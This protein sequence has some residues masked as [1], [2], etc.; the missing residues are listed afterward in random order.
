VEVDDGYY[1]AV[2]P[3]TLGQIS[4]Y[5]SYLYDET[6]FVPNPNP[7][8]NPNSN[9]NQIQWILGDGYQI[10]A[11]YYRYFQDGMY[12]VGLGPASISGAAPGVPTEPATWVIWDSDRVQYSFVINTY[13][14]FFPAN[15]L[16]TYIRLKGCTN[17]TS[18]ITNMKSPSCYTDNFTDYGCYTYTQS[19]TPHTNHEGMWCYPVLFELRKDSDGSLI[20]QSQ[21]NNPEP[22]TASTLEYGESYK[23]T[24]VDAQGTTFEEVIFKNAPFSGITRD[25]MFSP[26]LKKSAVHINCLIDFCL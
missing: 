21:L 1:T 12:E 22:V 6:A 15:S 16:K 8:P 23:L 26:I 3:F 10:N 18:I 4:G 9:C 19:W 24:A 17:S 14:D 7:N 13:K 2:V 5:P 25:P 20:W 11:D